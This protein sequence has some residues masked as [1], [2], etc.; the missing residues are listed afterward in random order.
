VL[1]LRH[2]LERNER[3]L[4]T[5]SVPANTSE[6]QGQRKRRWGW[7]VSGKVHLDPVIVDRSTDQEAASGVEPARTT[8]NM[9]GG[10]GCM[11]TQFDLDCWREPPEI[12]VT[13]RSPDD[14]SGLGQVYLSRHCLHADVVRKRVE[15]GHRRGVARE[16][17]GSEGIDNCQFHRHEHQ[18]KRRG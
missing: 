13:V 9:S 7:W 1:A 18:P 2:H 6:A 4:A 10:E 8:K 14:E 17:F 15:D 3:V 11:P 16:R 12:M 5:Q